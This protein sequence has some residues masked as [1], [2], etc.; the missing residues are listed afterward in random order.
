MYNQSKDT[1]AKGVDPVRAEMDLYHKK[2]EMIMR[3]MDFTAK[4]YSTATRT[5]GTKK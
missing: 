4:E 3:S 5:G 2:A 1:A